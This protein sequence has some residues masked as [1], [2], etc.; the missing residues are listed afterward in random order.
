[1]THYNDICM[2]LYLQPVQLKISRKHVTIY[3]MDRE[4]LE[5]MLKNSRAETEEMMRRMRADRERMGEQ[6]R[7]Q[8]E[9]SKRQMDELFRRSR[10]ETEELMKR[11]REDRDSFFR[12]L[13]GDN[14][15]REEAFRESTFDDSDF[16]SFGSTEEDI[17]DEPASD[18]STPGSTEKE[19]SPAEKK[20]RELMSTLPADKV[21]TLAT[22]DETNVRS[23]IATVYGAREVNPERTDWD[24]YI[25]YRRSIE[26][27]NP[28]PVMIQKTQIANLLLEGNRKDAKFPF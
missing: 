24:I 27:E 3:F 25:S 22:C 26:I 12:D 23:F 18:T 8:Q 15:E 20:R 21:K 19:L 4:S 13:F 16:G 11:M 5:D 17:L 14:S 28:D 6:L 7:Q 9:E 1:M 2:K 10:A